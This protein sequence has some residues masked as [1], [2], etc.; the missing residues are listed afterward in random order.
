VTVPTK[1]IPIR[2]PEALVE[3]LDVPTREL[4]SDRAS[5]LRQWRW[6]S[7]EKAAVALVGEGKL[8]IDKASELL[9]QSHQDIYRIARDNGIELGATVEQKTES[10]K[11]LG[12]LKPRKRVLG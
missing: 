3:L 5:V 12:N 8:S 7:A 9:D 6:Q 10:R 4:R 2:L 1:S 11:N